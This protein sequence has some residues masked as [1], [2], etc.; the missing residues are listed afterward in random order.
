MKTSKI[1]LIDDEQWVRETIAMFLEFYGYSN[2]VQA[3]DGQEGIRMIWQHKPDLV[4]TDLTMP[5]IRGE[6]VIRWISC[7]HKP[8]HP[9]IRVVALSADPEG[10]AEPA[11]RAAGAD[12]FLSKPFQND[13]LKEAVEG[14][15]AQA[16]VQ[17]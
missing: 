3:S 16:Q 15:L 4:I 6:E 13:E 2:I 1:L 5:G 10:T 17:I 8:A 11:V 14:L 12:A 9:E 7:E